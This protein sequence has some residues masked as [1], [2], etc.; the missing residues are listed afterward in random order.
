MVGTGM[1]PQ[2]P[3]RDSSTGD[4]ANRSKTAEAIASLDMQAELKKFFFGDSDNWSSL[5][6]PL[7]A[8]IRELKDLMVEKDAKIA[9]LEN[10]CHELYQR[11]GNLQQTCMGLE[12]KCDALEQYSRRNSLRLSGVPEDADEIC[13][14]KT[15]TTLNCRLG[16]APP[17][18]KDDIDRLHRTGKKNDDGPPRQ[19]LIKFARYQERHRVLQKKM[20]LKNTGLFLSE[21]LTKCR[22]NLLY[23]A[24]QRKR[25]G[26]LEDCWSYD[27]RIMVKTLDGKSHQITRAS[28]FLSLPMPPPQTFVLER[29]P[30]ASDAVSDVYDQTSEI[31]H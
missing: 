21:D 31:I 14:N 23:L 2:T 11:C 6:E 18:T 29:N 30:A 22:N 8:E 27:G 12:K 15:L 3:R 19:I 9:H 7:L 26:Q 25:E 16:L 28:D 1:Q 20:R 5:Q 17:L 13:L 4:R 10:T 24:R